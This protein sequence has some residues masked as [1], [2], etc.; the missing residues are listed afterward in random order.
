MKIEYKLFLSLFSIKIIDKAIFFLASILIFRHDANVSDNFL[1]Y[2]RILALGT[3]VLSFGI[4]QV[5][6]RQNLNFKDIG[7]PLLF[8]ISISLLSSLIFKEYLFLLLSISF[9][10]GLIIISAVLLI[11]E[12]IKQSIIAESLISNASLILLFLFFQ[13]MSAFELIFYSRLIPFVVIMSVFINKINFNITWFNRINSV[14]FYFQNVGQ[15]IT[16]NIDALAIRKFISSDGGQSSYFMGIQI[17]QLLQILQ[18]ISNKQLLSFM[19]KNLLS[20]VKKR[21]RELSILSFVLMVI[22]IFTI[23]DFFYLIL[24]HEISFDIHFLLSIAFLGMI[25]NIFTGP[26]EFYMNLHS[27]V[28]IGSWIKIIVMFFVVCLG[29]L[30]HYCHSIIFIS[31]LIFN[32]F[33]LDNLIRHFYLKSKKVNIHV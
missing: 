31:L 3:I 23:D 5:V 7:I 2:N 17:I 15:S 6:I 11:N 30:V 20:I 24:K 27:K 33:C 12:K 16:K 9:N 26:V 4:K 22:I 21:V 1:F 14:H 18:E 10:V 13:K 29:A 28:N 32:S 25:F 19:K 8:P